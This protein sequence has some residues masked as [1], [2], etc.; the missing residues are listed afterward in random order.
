MNTVTASDRVERLIPRS[1]D[2]G[3][4]MRPKANLEPPL[5]N[6]IVNPATRIS[7]L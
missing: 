4:N 5:K 1:S 7:R 6:R 3:F 2:I